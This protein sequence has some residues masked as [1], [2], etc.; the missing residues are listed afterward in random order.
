[1]KL[2]IHLSGK[3]GTAQFHREQDSIACSVTIPKPLEEKF[4]EMMDMVGGLEGKDEGKL[5]WISTGALDDLF[6]DISDNGPSD[7]LYP[8]AD[9]VFALCRSECDCGFTH[10]IG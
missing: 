8:L 3:T 7:P 6:S 5:P 1:M 4:M 10:V 2:A 9:K